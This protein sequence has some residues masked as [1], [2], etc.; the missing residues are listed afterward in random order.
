MRLWNEL[1][2]AVL[3]QG[4]PPSEGSFTVTDNKGEPLYGRVVPAVEVERFWVNVS[5]EFPLRIP[6]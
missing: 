2:H 4:P 3:Q 6:A 1:E 5:Y